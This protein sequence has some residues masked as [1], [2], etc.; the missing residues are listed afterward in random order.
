MKLLVSIGHPAHVHAFK[1]LIW[2]M[3]K[4]GHKIKIVARNKDVTK[5]LLDAYNFDFTLISDA[6]SGRGGLAIELMLRFIFFISIIKN[7]NPNIILSVMDPSIAIVAKIMRKKYISLADAEHAKLIINTTLP[8][9][10]IVLT[11]SSFKRDLGKKHITYNGYDELAYLHPNYFTPN[12]AVLKELNLTQNDKYIIMRFVSWEAFHDVGQ[13][14]LTMEA[15]RKAIKEFEK[16]GRVLISSESLLPKEFE[17]YRITS[18]PEKM[19]DL[20][21]YATLFFG[22]GATMA[23]ESALL[24]TPAIYVNSLKLGY[25]EDQEEKYELVYN[26]NDANPVTRCEKALEKAIGLLGQKNLKS[27]WQEKREKLLNEKIDTTEFMVKFIE[28]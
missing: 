22:E 18:S 1:N 13:S 10:D 3:E 7:F 6:K 14:G 23:T 26:F 19:H 24:G 8:F 27:K 25:L 4:R 21:Y 11:S 2:E 5:K 9:T 16:Y 15:K 12:R 20:M 28:G 17:K